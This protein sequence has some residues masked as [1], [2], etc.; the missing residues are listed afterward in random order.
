MLSLPVTS[1]FAA[2]F[3]LMLVA[4]S[5]IVSGGR[6]KAKVNLGDGDNVMLLSRI[7]A[8]GN[9]VEY[10]P[11][12]LILLGLCEAGGRAPLLLWTLGIALLLGRLS[13]A[14]GMMASVTPLR[15]AG[16][17]LTYLALIAGAAALLL[18]YFA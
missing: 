9:F 14:V 1:L 17:L 4:L 13:H 11:M 15:A 2:L 18:A 5:F 8:Q 6:M 3:A 7:R 10:V 12:G 16:M